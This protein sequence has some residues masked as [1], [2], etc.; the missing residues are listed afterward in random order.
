MEDLNMATKYVKGKL[1]KLTIADLQPDPN[2]ARS[3]MDPNALNELAASIGKFGVLVPIQFCQ[4]DQGALV[5]VSGH[6]R[7]KAAEKAGL[8]E[9]NG[10]FTDGDTRLQGFVDN[11]QRE[12]LS[13]VDEAEQMAALMKEYVFNQYQLAEALGKSQAAVSTTITL[14]KLPEDVRDAC[15]TNPNI[16]KTM[17]LEAAKEK[18]EATMRRKFKNY[19]DKA[20]KATQPAEVKQRL[21]KQR[22]LIMQTDG[23]TGKLSGLPW[24]EWSEDDRNDLTNALLG[25]RSQVQ[26]LLRDMNALPAEDQQNLPGNNNLS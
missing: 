19:M 20:G 5:I 25:I 11:L 8:T 7:V 18:T 2:Q 24:Q 9:I 26:D 17:L 22:S 4:N 6:R 1:Y 23:L 3:F 12:G 14:N 16:P 13:P 21:S 15:R 10:T